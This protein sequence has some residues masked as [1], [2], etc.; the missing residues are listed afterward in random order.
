LLAGRSV[1]CFKLALRLTYKK[2]TIK[3]KVMV[4]CRDQ[5]ILSGWKKIL[6]VKVKDEKNRNSPI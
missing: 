3:K 2:I 4:E 6:S 1:L 5:G